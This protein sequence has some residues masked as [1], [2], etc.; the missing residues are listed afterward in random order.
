VAPEGPQLSLAFAVG[1]ASL[2]LA[3]SVAVGGCTVAPSAAGTDAGIFVTFVSDLN[4]F[5]R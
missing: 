5:H 1:R 2:V 4:D 3:L